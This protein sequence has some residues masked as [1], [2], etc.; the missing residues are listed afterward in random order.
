MTDALKRANQ[1]VVGVQV[2]AAEGARSTKNLRN[3][4]PQ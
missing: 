2:G 4:S 1:A 3:T